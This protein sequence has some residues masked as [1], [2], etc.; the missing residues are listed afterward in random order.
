MLPVVIV[1][2]V[3]RHAPDASEVVAVVYSFFFLMCS[4]PPTNDLPLPQ[5]TQR[6]AVVHI[7]TTRHRK[8]SLV[9]HC[10]GYPIGTNTRCGHL[11]AKKSASLKDGDCSCLFRSVVMTQW[12]SLL[13]KNIFGFPFSHQGTSL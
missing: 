10:P 7:L 12:N 5:N 6:R 9:F 4:L 2:H 1:D 8:R 13:N 3:H 11:K